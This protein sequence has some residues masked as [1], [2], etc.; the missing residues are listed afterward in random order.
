MTT[1]TVPTVPIGPTTIVGY[2]GTVVGLIASILVLIFPDGDQQTIALV[3]S[4]LF[5]LG[6]FL[7]TQIGRYIQARELAKPAPVVVRVPISEK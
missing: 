2:G 6:S 5:T 3:A 1:P 4:S 7:V